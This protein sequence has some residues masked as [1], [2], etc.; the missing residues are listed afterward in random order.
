MQTHELKTDREVFQAVLEGRKKFEIR[1]DDRGFAVGDRLNLLETVST[2]EEMKAGAP[3]EYT[4]GQWFAKVTHILRGPIY[5]LAVG[6]VIMSIEDEPC[7]TLTGPTCCEEGRRLR[8]EVC[9]ECAEICAGFQ[10][11]IGPAP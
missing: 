9:D 5:G 4:G 11:C 2:G 6:W 8:V 7:D 1:K 3:L 10:G